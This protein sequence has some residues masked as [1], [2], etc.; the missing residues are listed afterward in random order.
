[1]HRVSAQRASVQQELSK[2]QSVNT[3]LKNEA[4]ILE[5]HVQSSCTCGC[6]A[7]RVVGV[8]LIFCLLTYCGLSVVL[9]V[10][11][12]VCMYVVATPAVED[13]ASEA[14]LQAAQ[15]EHTRAARTLAMMDGTLWYPVFLSIECSC[16]YIWAL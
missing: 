12:C 11:V 7:P 14:A 10:D 5:A 9:S 15:E 4:T 13:G 8:A 2:L 3:A 6:K 1:M 16:S